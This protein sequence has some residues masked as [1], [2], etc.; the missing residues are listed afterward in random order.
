MGVLQNLFKGTRKVSKYNTYKELGTYAAFF[1]SFGSDMY[2]SAL[3]RSCIR[4]LAEHSSKANARCKDPEIEKMLNESPNMY[5]NGKDFLYK[6]RTILEI[7]NTSFI[8]IERAPNG[9]VIGLYPVPYSSYEAVESGNYLFIRFLFEG[10][11]E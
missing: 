9:K 2:K 11:A 1:S 5:M 4:P 3:V 7:K 10:N 8:F 6:V